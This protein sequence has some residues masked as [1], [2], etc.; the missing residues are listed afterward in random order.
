M[1]AI[2]LSYKN[3]DDYVQKIEHFARQIKSYVESGMD[4]HDAIQKAFNGIKVPKE[5]KIIASDLAKLDICLDKL[6]ENIKS[7]ENITKQIEYIEDF[8]IPP[9]KEYFGYYNPL[10]RQ[11]YYIKYLYYEYPIKP[12]GYWFPWHNHPSGVSGYPSVVDL[13]NM[14]E[15]NDYGPNYSYGYDGLFEINIKNMKMAKKEWEK[16]KKE[17]KIKSF[18]ELIDLHNSHQLKMETDEIAK[19]I[20]ATITREIINKQNNDILLNALNIIAIA[21]ITIFTII[22][23]IYCWKFLYKFLNI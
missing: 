14:I 4:M 3:Y 1:K 8:E 2:K 16:I 6:D 20:G 10:T 15:Q 22:I 7:I 23:I 11:V 17:L 21:F 19:R 12:D 9:D 18:K 13:I 5:F